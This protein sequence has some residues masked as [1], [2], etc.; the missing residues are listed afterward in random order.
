MRGDCGGINGACTENIV[1]TVVSAGLVNGE[2]LDC[3]EIVSGRP[4]HD[5]GQSLRVPYAEIM[6]SPDCEKGHKDSG[7]FFIRIKVHRHQIMKREP[8]GEKTSSRGLRRVWI[9]GLRDFL[10]AVTG[11]LDET[12]FHERH[13]LRPFLLQR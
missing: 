9:V 13:L 6:P 8:P 1:G 4:L 2:N 5:F 10:L 12:S 3:P 11:R 7:D